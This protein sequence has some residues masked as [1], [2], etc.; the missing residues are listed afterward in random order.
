M[1]TSCIV[2]H[3]FRIQL[4]GL[5]HPRSP[6]QISSPTSSRRNASA[7]CVRQEFSVQRNKT[8]GLIAIAS[9]SYLQELP[10]FN[11]APRL[12]EPRVG[13]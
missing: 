7:I 4:A 6:S 10:D 11:L 2:T 9:F 1:P 13:G 5:R 12:N 8:F 3:R